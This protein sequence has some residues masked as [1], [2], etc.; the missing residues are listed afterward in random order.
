VKRSWSPTSLLLALPL[1]GVGLYM[2]VVFYVQA[3][4]KAGV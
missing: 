2:T 1:L 3:R 4:R